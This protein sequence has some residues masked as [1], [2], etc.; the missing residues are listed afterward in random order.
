MQDVV[1]LTEE[2]LKQDYYY[3]LIWYAN[4]CQYKTRKKVERYFELLPQMNELYNKGILSTRL[5][6]LAGEV[7]R[8]ISYGIGVERRENP[9]IEKVMSIV[10]ESSL[11]QYL[12]TQVMA[13]SLKTNDTLF[14]AGKRTQFDSIVVIP[15]LRSQIM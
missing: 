3:A 5:F 8:Y 9:S 12:Y 10:G 14:F 11:N 13:S 1:L 4:Q 6:D 15:H 2:L 7:S